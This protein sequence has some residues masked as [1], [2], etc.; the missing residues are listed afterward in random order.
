MVE[1]DT[2]A[3]VPLKWRKYIK[4]IEFSLLS[5][6]ELQATIRRYSSASAADLLNDLEAKL[7]EDRRTQEVNLYVIKLVPLLQQ[8]QLPNFRATYREDLSAAYKFLDARL[9]RNFV[10]VWLCQTRIDKSIFSVAGRIGFFGTDVVR[11]QVVEQ[12][13][14]CSPRLIE[15]FGPD[16]HFPYARASRRSWGWRYHVEALHTPPSSDLSAEAQDGQ[17]RYSLLSIE[18]KKKQIQRFL[19]FVEGAGQSNIS[20]EY[21]IVGSHISV[22]DWDTSDDRRVLAV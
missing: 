13:W 14:R 15:S 9:L 3:L 20:L 19:E 10:E 1:D 16:F 8:G 2:G 18:A 12:V 5:L 6:D 21:K 17:F 22:I 11:G 7:D 4:L